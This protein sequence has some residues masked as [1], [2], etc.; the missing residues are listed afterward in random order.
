MVISFI[1]TNFALSD[2]MFIYHGYIVEKIFR[3]LAHDN[4][5]HGY[6]GTGHH[7]CTWR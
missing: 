4:G 1:I 7:I 5:G 2:M 6:L 3:V